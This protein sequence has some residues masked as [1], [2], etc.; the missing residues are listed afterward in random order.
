MI[1]PGIGHISR[2]NGPFEGN[3]PFN[4]A[5]PFGPAMQ[6]FDVFFT[7]SL[8]KL[9]SRLPS[10]FIRHELMYRHYTKLIKIE[11]DGALVCLLIVRYN[12]NNFGRKSTVT[13]GSG[14]LKLQQQLV[15]SINTWIFVGFDDFTHLTCNRMII[16]LVL[17]YAWNPK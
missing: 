16:T 4:T 13:I 1:T 7:I 2:N 5:I 12:L 17:R 8:N 14:L 6:S 11:L 9:L 10:D 15:T 3:L